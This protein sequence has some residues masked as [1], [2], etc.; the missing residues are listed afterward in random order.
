MGLTVLFAEVRA[1]DIHWIQVDGP[2]TPV[3][4]KYIIDAVDRAAKEDAELLI[5]QMDTPGGLMQSTWSINK[6]LL[7]DEV[8]VAVY[9]APSGG[10]AASAG[11]FISYAAHIVAMAPSTNIGSAHPVSM[12]GQDTSKVMTEKVVN[13]AVAHIRG[14][15]AKR[16]R[17]ADWAEK[18]VQQ[19]VSITETEALKLG[20]AD[21]IAA[22]TDDLLKQLNGRTVEL[23][24]GKKSLDT[25]GKPIMRFPMSWRYR[26]L[27]KISDPNIA[28]LLMLAGI[29]GIFFELQNP[30]AIFPGALGGISLVLAFFALQVLPINASGILL[31][32]L[33]IV[34]FILEINIASYGLL[35]IGGIVSMTLG[36]LMLFRTPALR[37][38]LAIIIPAVLV[39]AAFFIFAI[40]MAL[41]ARMSKATT[42]TQGIIGEKGEIIRACRPEGQVAVHGE[43]WKAVSEK[44]LKK[45]EKVEVVAV[46]GMVLKVKRL[47]E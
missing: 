25:R 27:D 31:I 36:S 41:R 3:T 44:P 43:I 24:E 20:V 26:I 30:G 39:T 13:D 17:N 9:I 14:A 18:A 46:E 19:S 21:L 33:A 47:K 37:V 10:R 15:A 28:Y 29:M 35:T 7:A 22:N 23:K 40:G 32:L 42:G 12:G 8:P 11:V 16:G 38:S 6:A 34:F 5:I 1:G 4:A 2:I 45:G